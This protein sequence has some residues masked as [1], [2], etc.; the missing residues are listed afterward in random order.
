MQWFRD[1][2][3]AAK[4]AMG[5]GIL[6]L[7]ALVQGAMSLRGLARLDEA[8]VLVSGNHVPG[9]LAL[10]DAN[11]D[12][13]RTSRAVRNAILDD[14]REAVEGRLADIRT[15][16]ESFRRH[17]RRFDSTVVLPRNHERVRTLLADFDVM[18]AKQDSIA[19]LALLQ[20]DEEARARLKDA[21]AAS[22]RVDME[23]DTLVASKAGLLAQSVR[24]SEAAYASARR[25][26]ATL[27]ALATLLAVVVA[28]VVTRLITVP[29]AEAAARAEQLRRVCIA[30]LR[31]GVERLAMG[32]LTA[33][34][35]TGTEPL[36]V[37]SADEIGAMARALNGIIE[38]TQATVHA[39]DEALGAMRT[40]MLEVRQSADH[41]TSS[42]GELTSAALQI[43][44]GAQ[45]Q[46]SS[47]EETAASL[48]EMTATVKQNAENAQQAAQLATAARDVAEQGGR[49]VRDAVGAM[50][51]INASSRRIADIITTIDEIAFQTNLLALNAAVEAARAGAQG[52]GF[53]VVAGEVRNLAQRSATAAREIKGLIQDS[54][55]K[56]ED[57]STLVTRSGATLDEIVA[58]V[59]RVTDIV[60][61]IAAASREQATGIDQVNK[62]VTQMDTVTQANAGQ[63]E[64]LSGTAEALATQA[65]QLQAMVARFTLEEGVPAAPER[66]PARPVR[67]KR[68]ELV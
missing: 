7:L 41:T 57:G 48:E 34:V 10:K 33:R 6:V 17:I 19:A 67:A 50:G 3:T 36:R 15:Y 13:L 66:A 45:E 26:L 32:D 27:I 20:R 1:A 9:M 29:L 51:E 18:R 4:L 65:Q 16:D 40:A 43:S 68:R 30:N 38:G 22:D 11:I 47:L 28:T 42:S 60:A 61:E 44:S 63:T 54:V 53:A 52:R 55:R 12:L 25:S 23:L 21:R 58:S 5:F 8:I 2:R 62:A 37:R 56:V 35:A 64:E 31:D 49:V 59:K 39:F 14:T 24:E 46:A